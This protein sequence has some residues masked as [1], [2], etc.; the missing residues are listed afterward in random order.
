MA[1]VAHLPVAMVVVLIAAVVDEGTTS[2]AVMTWALPEHPWVADEA[3]N[4][5]FFS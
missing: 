5:T 4:A 3:G 1:V 2:E